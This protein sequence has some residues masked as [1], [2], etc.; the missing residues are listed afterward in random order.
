MVCKDMITNIQDR[1]FQVL[2]EDKDGEVRELIERIIAWE[3]NNPPKHEY[4]GFYWHEVYGDPRVLNKLVVKGILKVVLKT[5]SGAAYRLVDLELT[6]NALKT[7]DKLVEKSYTAEEIL[8]IPADILD[9]VIGHEDKKEIIMRA[10]KSQKRCHLLLYGS[11]ASSKSLILECLG[12]L[13]GSKKIIGSSSTKA[14]LFDLLYNDEPRFLLIDE[15]DKIDNPRD[16]SILLSLMETG[17]IYE[18]KFGRRRSKTLNTKVIAA[19]NNIEKIPPELL[20]RFIR[21]RF[22]DYSDNEFLEVSTKVLEKRENIPPSLSAYI[23]GQVLNR[24]RSKDVRDCVKVARLLKEQTRE[25]VDKIIDLMRKQV[26]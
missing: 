13:P 3:E 25:D 18:T 11:P 1:I 15:I 12:N 2:S 10:I 26:I 20:S 17:K 9:I 6:K 19:A 16:L 14:G 7:Y 22:K 21:L 5:N 4:H 24:L 8:E 23:A